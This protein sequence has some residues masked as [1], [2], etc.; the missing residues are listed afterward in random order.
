M[1]TLHIVS[2]SPFTSDALQRA[3]RFF[4]A[5]DSLLFIQ[6]GVYVLQ[7]TEPVPADYPCYVL[8]EDMLARALTIPEHTTQFTGV[9]YSGF[10]ELICQH[11]NNVNWA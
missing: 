10:V 1:S 4:Q 9:D 5:G 2:A 3:L 6:S 7:L 11:H 8:S